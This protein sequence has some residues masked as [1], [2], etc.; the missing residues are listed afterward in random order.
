MGGFPCSKIESWVQSHTPSDTRKSVIW[1]LKKQKWY[2]GPVLPG[3]MGDNPNI[4]RYNYK[5]KCAVAVNSSTAFIFTMDYNSYPEN[6]EFGWFDHNFSYNIQ[7]K[8]WKSHTKP[9]PTIQPS[10]SAFV[11]CAL[12][13]TKNYQRK[14]VHICY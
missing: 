4:S 5:A 11:S 1:S 14:V 8:S 6:T 9:P 2:W 3:E 12:S 7:T 13:H 10:T